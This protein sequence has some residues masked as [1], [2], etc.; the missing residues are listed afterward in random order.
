MILWTVMP[1]ELVFGEQEASN[2][3]EEI[4][5]AGTK[6]MVERLSPT[7]GK[8]VRIIS[9]NPADFL[10]PK[11]QPGTRLTYSITSAVFS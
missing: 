8:I 1:L 4:E 5:Y 2:A 11:Y 6:L 3:Y 10:N 7:E 9:S